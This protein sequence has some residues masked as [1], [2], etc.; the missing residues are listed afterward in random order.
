MLGERRRR[1]ICQL[2]E[3][4]GYVESRQL[5]LSLGVNVSTVRRD[6]EALAEAGLIQ[7]T[8]GGAMPVTDGDPIDVPYEVKRRERLAAKRA[9]ANYAATFVSEWRIPGPRQRLDHLRPRPGDPCPD[10]LTV[11]T[12]DLRIAHYLAEGGGIRLLVTGGQL[13]DSVFTLVGPS[14]LTNLE[15]LQVDWAFLGADAVDPEA[16][17]TNVNTVEVPIKQAMLAAAARKVLLADSSKFGRRA[18]ATVVGIDAFDYVIT[19]AGLPARAS[20]PLRRRLVRVPLEAKGRAGG[21]RARRSSD[22]DSRVLSW[23][24]PSLASRTRQAPSLKHRSDQE[25][26]TARA[27]ARP[28]CMTVSEIVQDQA[29]VFRAGSRS[30]LQGD[31]PGR[32]KAPD[33]DGACPSP[34]RHT[35][36]QRGWWCPGPRPTRPRRG[37]RPR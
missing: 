21:P 6:L 35:A 9:I 10:D 36:L 29:E 27:G 32:R 23:A 14:A 8:H 3:Q 34:S 11:A 5:A 7:R 17:V 26:E 4:S 13:I 31:L 33:R 12:N 19:D 20:A 15:G 37:R 18:L 24:G 25:V 22:E 2:I 16:G 28:C 30:S 1:D